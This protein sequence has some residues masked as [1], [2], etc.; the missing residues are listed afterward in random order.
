MT[1][2]PVMP[3]ILKMSTEMRTPGNTPLEIRADCDEVMEHI[4]SRKPLDPSVYRRVRERSDR[5]TD[6]IRRNHG[7]LN[8]AVQLVRDACIEE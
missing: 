4:L 3:I 1:N 8:V 6:E 7:V 2:R 5:I